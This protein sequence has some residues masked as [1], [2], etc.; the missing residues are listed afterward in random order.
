MLHQQAEQ[1]GQDVLFSLRCS[2]SIA[3]P[4]LELRSGAV[5]LAGLAQEASDWRIAALEAGPVALLSRIDIVAERVIEEPHS[6]GATEDVP[7]LDFESAS[8][9]G[10]QDRG[11][12]SDDAEAFPAP[13]SSS[14]SGVPPG[15]PASSSA[16]A[17]ASRPK[18]TLH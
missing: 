4:Q 6:L 8:E 7:S 3:Y 12:L 16:A 17:S 13:P 1:L 9:G 11:Y 15:V 18:R 5:F 10:A 2:P 14:S